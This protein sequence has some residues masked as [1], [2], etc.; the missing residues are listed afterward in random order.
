MSKLKNIIFDLGNVLLDIDFEL[1][2]QAFRNLG[3]PHFEHMYSLHEIDTFFEKFER[4]QVT[5]NTFYEVLG[6]IGKEGISKEEITKAWNT[7]LLLPM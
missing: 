5:V 4:G 1:T 3:F 7:M 6:K 2:I